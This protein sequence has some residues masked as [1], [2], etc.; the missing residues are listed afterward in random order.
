MISN[1]LIGTKSANWRS[2][3]LTS[4]SIIADAALKQ[5]LRECSYF[6]QIMFSHAKTTLFWTITRAYANLLWKAD[7]EHRRG[8]PV[9]ATR[10]TY[11]LNVCIHTHAHARRSRES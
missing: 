7:Y 1:L 10:G 3:F 8:D 4:V 6:C 2:Q 5:I 9:C 11:H